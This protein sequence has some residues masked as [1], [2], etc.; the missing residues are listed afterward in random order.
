MGPEVHGELAGVAAGVGAELALVGPLVRVDPQ[1]LL[2]AAAVHGGV[3]AQVT[4]VGLHAGVA[5]HVHGQI[6][7]PAEALVAEFTLVWFVSF[8]YM[9]D[10]RIYGFLSSRLLQRDL[11][12]MVVW[13]H[14]SASSF[15]PN[16][17]DRKT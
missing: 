10:S 4:L 17:R 8:K 16:A 14:G 5:A 1:V 12:K 6:V 11:T 2:Q 9:K 13:A 7:L 3:V 15:C